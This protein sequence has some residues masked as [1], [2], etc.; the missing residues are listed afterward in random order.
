MKASGLRPRQVGKASFRSLTGLF[1]A[2]GC[3]VC[4]RPTLH[5]FCLDCQRQILPSSVGLSPELARRHPSTD[6]VMLPVMSLGIY[7]G[8]LKRA[9]LKLKYGDRPD[10]ARPFGAALAQQWLAQQ[11]F[12]SKPDRQS[13]RSLYALPIPLHPSR[14]QERG[15]N[16][17][18][19][20][21][22]AFCQVSGLPL[23][24]QGIVRI[25]ETL[26][27]HLLSLQARQ[28]N[29]TQAFQIGPSLQ[30]AARSSVLLIDDIYTTGTT[31]QSAADTLT[32]AGFT[33]RG[34]LVVAKATF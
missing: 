28:Q 5:P 22:R 34:I 6:G 10:L 14:Y 17:A 4:D 33:V 19:L 16:Q 1:L 21:A 12:A 8:P 29:L 20:V 7:D 11:A 3:A 30:R 23:L 32:Q 2:Q 27:M 15:Y 18:E 24:P 31:V 13:M 25:Q 9:I 26:P